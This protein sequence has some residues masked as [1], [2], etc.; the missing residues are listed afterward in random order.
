MSNSLAKSPDDDAKAQKTRSPFERFRTLEQAR[1]ALQQLDTGVLATAWRQTI[2]DFL[3]AE[4]DSQLDRLRDALAAQARLSRPCLD[5]SL[6]V[7]LQGVRSD[8]ALDIF[9]QA[10]HLKAGEAPALVILA[11]NI[12]GLA[13]QS[14]LPALAL[15]RP[16]LIKTASA[17]PL[18]T[19]VFLDALATR[20]PVLRSAYAALSW[21]GGTRAIEAPLIEAAGRV[22]AYGD[23]DTLADLQNR[24]GSK[25][26]EF[27]PKI[28][29]GLIG[30]Q[31]IAS[32]DQLS[33]V[34]SGLARDVALFDQ[35]GCLSV[36][37]VLT[38]GNT[39]NLAAALG[40]ALGELA[41]HWPMGRDDSST[42]AA[43]QARDEAIMRGAHVAE[44]P[45]SAGTVIL[46]PF[47]ESDVEPEVEPGGVEAGGEVRLRPSPGRRLVRIYRVSC[48]EQAIEQ[49][50][51]WR[52]SIQGVSLLGVPESI[53]EALRGLGVS[54][55][56]NPGT[57]QETDVATWH[58][59]GLAPL[60]AYL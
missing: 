29:L 31:A 1:P 44:M 46:E 24:A 32:D 13:V 5:A 33:R 11:S 49:L 42:S 2:D 18:F 15:R 60:E 28:S 34:A 21:A 30:R 36:Q 41:E 45:M 12:P 37:V 7:V 19:P 55:M 14:L 56:A 54:R 4:P 27:G 25:L 9:E 17:E 52:G 8:A 51:V 20:V 53:S 6:D 58:N 40:R 3:A 16:L 38:D 59:G 10:R 35:R 57:L 50:E 48:L 43:R 39:D 26:V 23:A 22:I 47:A